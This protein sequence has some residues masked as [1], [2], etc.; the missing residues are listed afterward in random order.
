M[1]RPV[2]VGDLVAGLVG[3]FIADWISFFIKVIITI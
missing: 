3:Y 2:T 1:N